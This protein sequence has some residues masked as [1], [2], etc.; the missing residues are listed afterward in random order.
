MMLV[1]MRTKW[2]TLSFI[3]CE[4]LWIDWNLERIYIVYCDYTTFMKWNGNGFCE[5]KLFQ[6]FLIIVILIIVVVVSIE[7]PPTSKRVC[8]CGENN[9]TWSSITFLPYFLSSFISLFCLYYFLP[10][11]WPA[12][13]NTLYFTLL[14]LYPIFFYHRTILCWSQ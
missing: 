13:N 6:V 10:F 7:I 9:V 1:G 11:L 3:H 4:M 2:V 14:W 12:T 5:L 8:H